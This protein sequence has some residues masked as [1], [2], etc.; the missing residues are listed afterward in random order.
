MLRPIRRKSDWMIFARYSYRAAQ[1]GGSGGK[2]EFKRTETGSW[3]A[4]RVPELCASGDA[5]K[6]FRL[7]IELQIV[8]FPVDRRGFEQ[9]SMSAHLA[10]FPFIHYDDLVSLENRR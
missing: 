9:L 8:Q 10:N 4:C 3:T 5:S 6:V 1:E 2:I 7:H